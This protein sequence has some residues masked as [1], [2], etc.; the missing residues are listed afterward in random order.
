MKNNSFDVYERPEAE[1][2]KLV[3]ES[4]FL[5]QMETPDCPDNTLNPWGNESN[6]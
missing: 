2:V 3:V 6:E 5:S 1:E 4:S